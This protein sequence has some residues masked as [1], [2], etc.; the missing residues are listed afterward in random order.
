M[1]GHQLYGGDRFLVLHDVFRQR[2]MWLVAVFEHETVGLLDLALT[3]SKGGIELATE[4]RKEVAFKRRLDVRLRKRTRADC[5]AVFAKQHRGD[6]YCK[7]T[8]ERRDNKWYTVFATTVR[9][10]SAGFNSGTIT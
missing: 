4:G 5:R 10:K 3:Q 2:R 6:F 7:L 1:P 9:N 8:R